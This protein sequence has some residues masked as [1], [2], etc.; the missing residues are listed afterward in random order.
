[1]QRPDAD[2]G[3]WRDVRT[4]ETFTVHKGVLDV[5]VERIAGRILKASK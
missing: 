2:G 4:G 3:T 5:P 1:M